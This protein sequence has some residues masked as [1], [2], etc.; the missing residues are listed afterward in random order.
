V[1]FLFYYA[2][3]WL[4]AAWFAWLWWQDGKAHRKLKLLSEKRRIEL[5]EL[6]ECLGEAVDIVEGVLVGETELDSFT[7]QPWK[8]ALSQEFEGGQDG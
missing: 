3:P 5:K 6:R 2:I 4:F 1:R 7:T 8:K